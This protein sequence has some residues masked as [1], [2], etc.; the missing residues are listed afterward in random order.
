MNESQPANEPARLQALGKYEILDTPPEVAYDEIAELAAQI[1]GAPIG[2]VAFLDER[3]QWM[4][5]KYG[6]PP[7]FTEC[8]REIT[9]CHKTICQNDILHVPDLTKDA[10]FNSSPLVTSAPN[11]RMYCGMP[12]ITPEGYALGTVCVVDFQPREI[13]FG[14]QESLR[15]LSHQA[16]AQLE[17][18]R[19]LLERNEMLRD[20]A[21]V[22]DDAEAERTKSERLLLNILP[23]TI[24]D[25]LKANQRVKPRFYDSVSVVFVDFKDFTRLV[26]NLEPAS[27]VEQLDQ[28]FSRFDDI[29]AQ[30]RLEKLKTIGDAF[31]AAGGLPEP[32]RT[33]AFD[34]CL[35]ALHIQ[36]SLAKVNRQREKLRLPLWQARIGV[37]TGQVV[38]GVVGKNKFTYDI[39]GNTVNVAERLE[40]ADEPG[41]VNISETTWNHVKSRFETEPRGSIEV[42]GKGPYA[43]Y[44]LN[45]IKPEYSADAGG[46]TPNAQ[47]WKTEAESG[48]TAD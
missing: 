2:L 6:L 36:D 8:P 48:A 38:A 4:K 5:A 44:F 30:F 3:R 40:A 15:R 14:Q 31:M 41:R 24:A 9:V 12:L 37:N 45:R 28:H 21:Q 27:L 32:N 7:D 22:R 23:R 47:F 20:L 43:M 11:I 35:A 13:S 19:Q 1:C 17:L 46:L 16:M 18:R 33:H 10:R 42:K 34:A 26:E 39:W 29:A 25:E